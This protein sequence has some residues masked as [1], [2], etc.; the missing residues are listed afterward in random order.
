MRL[1][2]VSGL[3]LCV[4]SFNLLTYSLGFAKNVAIFIAV[5]LLHAALLALT[6][7]VIFKDVRKG[8]AVT[9]LFITLTFMYTYSVAPPLVFRSDLERYVLLIISLISGLAAG[10]LTLQGGRE[11]SLAQ[12]LIVLSL[13]AAILDGGGFL[14]IG[15]MA[16]HILFLRTAANGLRF[17]GISFLLYLPHL[18]LPML[19]VDTSL[20]P[21]INLCNVLYGVGSELN[22]LPTM[23]LVNAVFLAFNAAYHKFLKYR[24]P[25]IVELKHI[26][27]HSL[28]S[29]M[30]S[31][32][33]ISVIPMLAGIFLPVRPPNS[34]LSILYA[35]I[36]AFP[37]SLLGSS[38]SLDLELSPMR[39]EL[40]SNFQQVRNELNTHAY[41]LDVLAVSPIFKAKIGG[42]L[43]TLERVGKQLDSI[44][45]FLSKPILS[46]SSI[47]NTA[48]LLM[49][50]RSDLA[51]IRD[52]VVSTYQSVV[53][54][55]KELYKWYIRINGLRDVELD[56]LIILAEHV[57]RFEDIPSISEGLTKTLK[58][59]CE[60]YVRTLNRLAIIVERV[61]DVKVGVSTLAQCSDEALLLSVVG[62][63]R[64]L[65]EDMLASNEL[66]SK[67]SKMVND[68]SNLK[69]SIDKLI[70][71]YTGKVGSDLLNSLKEL[72][73]TLRVP[74][75]QE[76][77]MYKVL[78]NM[79]NTCDVL[80]NI[81]A[82][83]VRSL[84]Y[85]LSSREEY[86]VRAANSLGIDYN[87]LTPIPPD[88]MSK[89]L[90][91]LTAF[92]DILTCY[93]LINWI[94]SKGLGLIHSHLLYI[95]MYVRVLRRINYLQLLMKYFDDRL[96]HGDVVLDDVPLSKESLKWFVNV[97][98]GVRKDVVL[99]GNTLKRLRG[100][101]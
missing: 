88:V 39:D 96:E 8:L 30:M 83:L 28:A 70:E 77:N 91:S 50:L 76:V 101:Y 16:P 5:S 2:E 95:E 25:K 68:L 29:Y 43:S 54:E 62:T 15:L 19:V 84:S 63:Y 99:D 18:L 48:T 52:Q 10:V 73:N 3:A 61:L 47:L 32:T 66:T 74:Q 49:R 78:T 92:Q 45:V 90:S 40:N 59:V 31:L 97:Y 12:T 98:V 100:R 7:F 37:I 11:V 87:L 26:V 23:L 4:I 27:H 53:N 57:K 58:K 67:I 21:H 38:W 80:R 85:E 13:P 55:V 1:Y 64:N 20:V 9:Y 35:S 65:L 24:L 51:G 56:E 6:S 17:N 33:M 14:P 81:L 34:Y 46:Q 86:L 94:S 44:E 89:S 79:M 82:K 41:V 93:D 71:E 60:L 72:S 42:C 69:S 22:L 75:H 36:P